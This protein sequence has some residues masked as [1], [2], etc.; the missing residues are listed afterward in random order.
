MDW[1]GQTIGGRFALERELGRGGMGS[2]YLGRD[3]QFRSRKVVVKV[4]HPNLLNADF[5]ARFELE[6]DQL[7][8]LEH[9]R[10]IHVYD[11]G[12]HEG[13]PYL[14]VQ[15]VDGG[16][17]EDRMT[18]GKRMTPLE[19]LGWLGP[20]AE[21]LD[22]IH[23]RGAVHRDIKPG[24]ILFDGDGN[25]FLSDF[26]ISTVMTSIEGAQAGQATGHLTQAGSWV[27]S[28]AYAPPEIVTRELSP[29]Y[30]QYSLAVVAYEALAGRLPFEGKSSTEIIT[31]KMRGRPIPITEKVAGIPS[32]AADAIMRA[33]SPERSERFET[34]VGFIEA[35]GSE[36]EAGSARPSGK[37]TAVG[38]ALDTELRRSG[39]GMGR[40][41]A[42][43]AAL[44]VLVGLGVVGV[45][46]LLGDRGETPVG[47]QP[48]DTAASQPPASVADVAPAQDGEP[49]AIVSAAEIEDARTQQANFVPS[50]GEI[51]PLPPLEEIG[52][53][54]VANAVKELPPPAASVEAELPFPSALEQVM[55]RM[56]APE[57][58]LVSPAAVEGDG[59]FPSNLSL[60]APLAPGFDATAPALWRDA[61]TGS[62]SYSCSLGEGLSQAAATARFEE[63]AARLRETV[64]GWEI[65]RAGGENDALRAEQMAIRP[66]RDLGLRLSLWSFGPHQNQLELWVENL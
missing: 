63:V 21:A 49:E 34:C 50:S 54:A 62:W 48:A 42:A 36:L 10:V 29:Q 1:T 53:D 43:A 32:G 65:H 35:F 44:A 27:G 60:C 55:R 17:L 39:G 31:A 47:Q 20:V 6:I 40:L 56:K 37:A 57:P 12:E 5:R 23:R 15:Y 41:V 66:T 26:G 52:E 61:D 3:E 2:V 19:V 46:R 59:P 58:L 18:E 33:L 22:F 8:E 9:P 25:P 16:D 30:D 45:P 13:V 11:A 38:P 28:P 24:N 14:V 4:P 51:R 64:P 7:V